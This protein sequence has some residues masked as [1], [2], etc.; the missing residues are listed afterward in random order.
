MNTR[1]E[2]LPGPDHPI[3]IGLNARGVVVR[4]AGQVVADTRN[5][6]K[7]Q[8]ASYPPVLYIPRGDVD[9]S[10]LQRTDHTTYCP[11]KGECSYYSI[12]G[13]GAKSVNAAWSY[14]KPFTSVAQIDH[15]LAFYPT[16]V[17]A[18]DES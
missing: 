13:A 11:Y 5:A 4:A 3:S 17:D 1:V 9:M 2:K 10:K 7:L 6:L 14:E 16:R 8:E 15:Y 12:P 18:I